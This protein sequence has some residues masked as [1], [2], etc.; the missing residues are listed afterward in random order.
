VTA[1]LAASLGATPEDGGTTFRLWS[2]HAEG[3]ELCL[4]NEAGQE[5]RVTLARGA[6]EVWAGSVQGVGEGQRYGYRVHGPFEPDQGHRFNPAKL[7]LDPYARRVEGPITLREEHFTHRGGEGHDD[8][9]GDDRDSSPFTPKSLVAA[10]LPHIDDAERPGTPMADSVIYELHVKG[11]TRLHPELPE[12]LRGTYAG[13]AHP[14]VLAHLRKLGVTAVE[15]LPVHQQLSPRFLLERGLIDY[16]GYNTIAFLAPDP[17]FAATNDPRAELR[18][19]VRALH[20][21]GLEVLLDVVYNHTGEGDELGPTVAFRGIDNAAY[22]RLD[23][24]DLR[25]YRNDSG[26]GNTLA[27]T[28]PAV[29]RLILDQLGRC[30]SLVNAAGTTHRGP[31][32]AVTTEAWNEVITT[33]LTG[34]FLACQVFGRHFLDA[35]GGSILNIASLASVLAAPGRTAYGA[36]KA[37]VAQLTRQL[38]VEWADRGV[39]V[40]CL[41]P[42]FIRTP[43]LDSLL[44][45]GRVDAPRLFD[46]TPMRRFG[47][48]TEIVG[49]AVFLAAPWASFITGASLVVDGGLSIFSHP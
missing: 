33:N 24:S 48:T 15:L 5:R 40:N 27:A 29:V 23:P 46:R 19:A 41:M 35:G 11:F 45:S 20:G 2:E 10:P 32:E 28:H 6:D 30:D 49:P 12:A 1:N 13:L 25:R 22:Y 21:A 4:F 34:T 7:L 3:V 26:T 8:Q 18:D 31:T 47:E 39:R 37:G 36:S 44:A 42:G 9:R 14:A 17:R 16:W 38:A 43:M